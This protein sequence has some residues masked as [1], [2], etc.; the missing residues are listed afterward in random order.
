MQ[1]REAE[2]R[3]HFPWSFSPA[4]DTNPDVMG[5]EGNH[6]N[7]QSSDEVPR[8]RMPSASRAGRSTMSAVRMKNEQSAEATTE[9]VSSRRICVKR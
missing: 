3:G 1:E 9:A 2:P 7:Y 8:S 5:Y 6:K 4:L